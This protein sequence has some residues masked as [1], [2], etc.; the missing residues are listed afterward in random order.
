MVVSCLQEGCEFL[1]SVLSSSVEQHG[2]KYRAP[3]LALMLLAHHLHKANLQDAL[4]HLDSESC[5]SVRVE[6]FLQ[7][8]K[9]FLNYYNILIS[10]LEV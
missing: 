1:R 2:T 9:T 4:Q 3:Y 8:N 5:A 10:V 6:R 7:V